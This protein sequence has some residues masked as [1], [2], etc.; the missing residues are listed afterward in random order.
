[1]AAAKHLR[2]ER[3]KGRQVDNSHHLDVSSW[4]HR[5]AFA[6]SQFTIPG[7]SVDVEV[8]LEGR[9][10]SR[11]GDGDV[12]VVS[13]E[14]CLKQGP[15]ASHDEDERSVPFNVWPNDLPVLIACLIRTTAL[16]ERDDVIP[17]L[18]PAGHDL[19][20]RLHAILPLEED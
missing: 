14:V 15:D 9:M 12:R 2:V 8:T 20:A 16:A 1:M 10:K 7:G 19:V 11:H 3:G 4:T 6:G 17:A 13:I 18:D 5:T